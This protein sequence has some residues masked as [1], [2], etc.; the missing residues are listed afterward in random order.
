M[1]VGRSGTL[2]VAVAAAWGCTALGCTAEQVV[3]APDT[4]S[5]PGLPGSVAPLTVSLGSGYVADCMG[6]L[7]HPRWVLS[8]AHCFSDSMPS[9]W[10]TIR[11]FGAA[12]QVRDVVLHPDAV[13]LTQFEPGAFTNADVVAAHDLALIPLK[14][15]V[16]AGRVA[17]LWRPAGSSEVE[18]LTGGNFVYGRHDEGAPVT[19][20]GMLQGMVAASELL[21]GEQPGELLSASGRVPHGGDSGGG[22]F[23]SAG[24]GSQAL[25][26]VIQNAPLDAERG[27][28]GL[29][30]LWLPEHLEF[31]ELSQTDPAEPD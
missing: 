22:G 4:P 20:V 7:V 31:L 15:A 23:V 18:E 9:S 14:F 3:V 30:P 13:A 27:T 24:D 16:D 28:F 12:T 11:D 25:L 2:L 8:A 17:L 6:S 5:E 29:V 10:V 21:A 1:L 19:D 26:G